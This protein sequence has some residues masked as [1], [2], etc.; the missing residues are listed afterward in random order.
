MRLTD[1]AA[2][3]GRVQLGKLPGWN[4]QR[5]ANAEVLSAGLKAV[6]TPPVAAQATHVYHQ[7]TVRVPGSG[8]RRDEL[9]AGLKERGVGCAVYYPTP[10]HLLEPYRPGEHDANREWD[11]P[12]TMR[13][14]GEVLSLPVHPSLTED[15]LSR[16][17]DTV[18]ELAVT[19]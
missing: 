3:I 15:D 14:A 2:A 6:V 17:V 11:L 16:I 13:A 18:N 7:Y 9:M 5:R 4:R 12:E 1:V 10:I 19:S 8:D